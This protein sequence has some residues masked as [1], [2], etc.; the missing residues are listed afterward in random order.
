[1]NKNS[2][3]HHKFVALRL[4][5]LDDSK[6]KIES[7]KIGPICKETHFE[8]YLFHI[9]LL[10]LSK[11]DKAYLSQFLEYGEVLGLFGNIKMSSTSHFV[12]FFPFEDFILMIWALTKN[13]F[14]LT[15][16]KDL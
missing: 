8:P 7:K 9:F 5:I 1:M 4:S 11:F 16:K 15:F 6:S 13:C 12:S 2:N 14:C 10:K 3:I